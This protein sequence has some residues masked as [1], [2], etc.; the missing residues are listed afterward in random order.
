MKSLLDCNLGDKGEG[1]IIYLDMDGVCTDFIGS[2]T[3]LF[4]HES[5]YSTW[6]PGVWCVAERMGISIHDLNLKVEQAGISFWADMDQYTYYKE[7]W[8]MLKPYGRI[9]FLSTPG[10]WTG[11]PTGKLL[12]LQ[13]RLGVNFDDW[14]F[15]QHKDLVH[16]SNA[17]LIDDNPDNCA[18]F[19]NSILFPQP[20]NSNI[21]NRMNRVEYVE[22]KLVEI[23]ATM[24]RS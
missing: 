2:V 18:M 13:K 10:I 8:N 19:P 22:E 17:I 7:L 21:W 15:T 9:V 11:A 20:W 23:A 3:K 6:P 4:N 16:K 14:I 1:M 5:L 24:E 12:W